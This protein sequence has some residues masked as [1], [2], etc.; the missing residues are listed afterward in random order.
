MKKYWVL[1]KSNLSVSIEYKGAL[2]TWM[3]FELVSLSSTTFLWLAVFRTNHT[4]GNYDFN[5]IIFYYILVPIIGGLTSIFV[6]EHLPR[7]IKDG[8]ISTDLMKPYSIAVANLLNQF[9]IKLVHLSIKLPVYI[10]IAGL[11]IY[12]FHIQVQLSTLPLALCFCV[13]SYIL[14]FFIDLALSYTAFWFD[15]VWSLSHLKTV[16]LMVFGGLS[17][18]ID[19]VPQNIRVIFN[20]LPFRFIYYFP[21]KVVQGNMP[22]NTLLTEFMQLILWI[23]IFFVIGK[24]LW[25]QGLRKYGA[26]G[27]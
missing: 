7:K 12:V 5:K 10:L 9:G 11:F 27:N 1:F 22:V 2:F 26:Y 20:I 21:I 18:P 19:L 24:L 15:D 8:A 6:S 3:L 16:M 25:R 17:F 14:H 13:F 4:V 23:V